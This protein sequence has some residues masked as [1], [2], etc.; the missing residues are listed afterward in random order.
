MPPVPANY[1]FVIAGVPLSCSTVDDTVHCDCNAY[2]AG[3]ICNGTRY[4]GTVTYE[5]VG[6]PDTSSLQIIDNS[7]C[8]HWNGL[9]YKRMND[10]VVRSV[11][12]EPQV[13]YAFIFISCCF[14]LTQ[15]IGTTN[16]LCSATRRC[17][18]TNS[19]KE[20]TRSSC[21]TISKRPTAANAVV[22]LPTDVLP[23]IVRHL[24]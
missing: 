12:T 2:L 14:F 22:P 21:K 19:S 17:K 4:T 5:I 3:Q 18:T 11:T 8:W 15:V 1:S 10:V 23:T 6:M 7:A 9:E 20:S 13:W 16:I 24:R